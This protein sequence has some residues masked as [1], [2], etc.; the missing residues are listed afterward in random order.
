M[1][2][3]V[4]SASSPA[5]G[6]PGDAACHAMTV[7]FFRCRETTDPFVTSDGSSPAPFA[8]SATAQTPQLRLTS[9]SST[10]AH[11]SIELLSLGAAAHTLLPARPSAPRGFAEPPLGREKGDCIS[12]YLVEAAGKKGCGG[13]F[14]TF[15]RGGGGGWGGRGYKGRQPQTC[16][17]GRDGGICPEASM[18]SVCAPSPGFWILSVSVDPRPN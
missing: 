9:A 4:A 13:F 10:D 15:V 8:H 12:R 5:N 16:V 17:W 2:A 11:S 1:A 3:G 6:G 14:E 18:A 7:R